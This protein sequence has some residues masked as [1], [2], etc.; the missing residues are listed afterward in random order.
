[1]ED[2]ATRGGRMGNLWAGAN[3]LI[4][5]YYSQAS[6][7]PVLQDDYIQDLPPPLSI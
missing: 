3:L 1:M 7:R 2:G 4:C 6:G 5:M